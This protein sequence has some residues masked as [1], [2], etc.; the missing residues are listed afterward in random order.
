MNKT[1]AMAIILATTVLAGCSGASDEAPTGQVV[2]TVDGKEITATE[3]SVE[4]GGLVVKDP[5]VMK[6]AQEQALQ[7][8]L[9]RK[10]LAAEAVKQ[11]LDKTPEA[12]MM[13]NKAEE[14]ALVDMLQRK[15][16]EAVPKPGDDEIRQYVSTHP[17]T[18]GQRKLFLVEQLIVPKATKDTVKAIEPLDTM[19]EIKAYL[20]SQ[21][22]ESSPGMG[23]VDAVNLS[24]ETAEKL[25]A[26]APGE[27]FVTFDGGVLRIN[28]ITE[29]QTVPITGDSAEK[30]AASK[31]QAERVKSQ[32]QSQIEAV[33]KAEMPKVKYNE[34][35]APKV[36]A[37]KGK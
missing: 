23:V 6:R 24:P 27:V 10:I 36:D 32:I 12:E 7:T 19:P 13:R 28:D 33:L 26:L 8:V 22:L 17:A 18:F 1:G 25:A 14:L 15:W 5:A 29:V 37:G 16:R 30:L 11:G 35:F 2:A 31:I 20:A 3:L 34:E 4:L 21:K 9:N